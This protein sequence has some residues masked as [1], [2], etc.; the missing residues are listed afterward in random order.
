L[1]RGAI[2][3]YAAGTNR[4]SIDWWVHFFASLS[5]FFGFLGLRLET[6]PILGVL[7]FIV[8]L[9]RGFDTFFELVSFGFGAMLERFNH[10]VVFKRVTLTKP[11]LILST[12]QGYN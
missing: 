2:V 11:S 7:I 10:G 9:G 1:P 8:A 6:M 5:S 4:Y 12:V 3:L